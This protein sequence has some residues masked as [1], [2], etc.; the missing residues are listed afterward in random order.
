M[1]VLFTFRGSIH[2]EPHHTF[3]LVGLHDETTYEIHFADG[4]SGDQMM[5]GRRLR[6]KGISVYLQNPL[7]SELVFIRSANPKS[8]NLGTLNAPNR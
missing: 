3:L 7:S 8:S 4:T 6:L 2:D 5:T 1:G